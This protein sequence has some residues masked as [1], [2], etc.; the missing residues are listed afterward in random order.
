ML[1]GSTTSKTTLWTSLVLIW[2]DDSPYSNQSLVKMIGPLI[3]HEDQSMKKSSFYNTQHKISHWK[4]TKL[5]KFLSSNSPSCCLA[6]P[7]SSGVSNTDSWRRGGLLENQLVHDSTY[8]SW[9]T[10]WYFQ[11]DI[12]KITI[13]R[14]VIKIENNLAFQG[15]TIWPNKQGLTLS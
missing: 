9:T 5:D 7:T 12:W 2:F 14:H 8:R 6:W 15:K 11:E 4:W 10:W 3:D 1:E 13:H